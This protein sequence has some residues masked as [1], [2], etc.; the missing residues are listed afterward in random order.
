MPP[1]TATSGGGGG[2]CCER[3]SALPELLDQRDIGFSL[4]DCQFS[5][6]RPK[7]TSARVAL[8]RQFGVE[9]SYTIES[10]YCGKCLIS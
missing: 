4:R 6:T 8:W 1:S 7:E 2:G 10:T 5:V 9:R 3:V